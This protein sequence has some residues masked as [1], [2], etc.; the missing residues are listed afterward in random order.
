MFADARISSLGYLCFRRAVVFKT[1]DTLLTALFVPPL[2]PR[3]WVEKFPSLK[4]L[5]HFPEN[6]SEFEFDCHSCLLTTI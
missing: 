6:L 4:G 5:S 3:E 1:S 2:R